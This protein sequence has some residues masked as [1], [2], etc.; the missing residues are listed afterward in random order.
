MSRAAKKKKNWYT[1]WNEKTKLIY[2]RLRK[3]RK[4]NSKITFTALNKNKKQHLKQKNWV[5]MINE[6]K[7]EKEKLKQNNLS[8]KRKQDC[9]SK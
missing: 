1:Y 3:W 8:S 7:I 5:A 4:I 2:N 9:K 6:M